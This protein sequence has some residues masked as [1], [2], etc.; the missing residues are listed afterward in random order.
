MT[1]AVRRNAMPPPSS[2]ALHPDAK[3]SDEERRVFCDWAQA[4]KRSLKDGF[5]NRGK[6]AIQ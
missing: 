4:E 5:L 3:L 2:Q 6:T 1:E